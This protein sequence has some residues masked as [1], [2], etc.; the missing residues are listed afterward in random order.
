[1]DIQWYIIH[2]DINPMYM[3]ILKIVMSMAMYI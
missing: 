2:D 1:M 3:L